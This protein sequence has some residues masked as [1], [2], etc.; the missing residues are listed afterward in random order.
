[1]LFNNQT[2]NVASLM[3]YSCQ[4]CESTEEKKPSLW[5]MTPDSCQATVLQHQGLSSSEHKWP[6]I[7]GTGAQSG[8]ELVY[9]IT[10]LGEALPSCITSLSAVCSKASVFKAPAPPLWWQSSLDRGAPKVLLSAVLLNTSF[11]PFTMVRSPLISPS[12]HKKWVF[13][14]H[15]GLVKF[16]YI[17]VL[18]TNRRKSRMES[19]IW[20]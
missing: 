6:H 4:K 18:K 8:T 15:G 14:D 9:E 3:R 20:T 19:S 7:L 5:F 11:F 16:R 1:M 2:A 10:H 13:S 17:I 12:I